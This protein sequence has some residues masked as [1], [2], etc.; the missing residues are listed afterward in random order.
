[1]E[2]IILPQQMSEEEVKRVDYPTR[3]RLEI[4]NKITSVTTMTT[5]AMVALN[6]LELVAPNYQGLL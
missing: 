3:L 6:C 1:M 2:T 5:V 4:V